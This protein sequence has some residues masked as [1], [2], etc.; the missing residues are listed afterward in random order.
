MPTS[1]APA[2]LITSTPDYANAPKPTQAP[3]AIGPKALN[4]EYERMLASGVAIADL[5]HTVWNKDRTSGTL[6]SHPPVQQYVP[7]NEYSLG[8]RS[9]ASEQELATR[10]KSSALPTA[11]PPKGK[12]WAPYVPQETVQEVPKTALPFQP[13]VQEVQESTNPWTPP[14]LPEISPYGA[15]PLASIWNANVPPQPAA[16]WNSQYQGPFEPPNEDGSGG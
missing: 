16:P 13:P 15:M 2:R 10:P 1:K 14:P 4:I 6:Q 3:A 7:Q 8:Y 5:P 11:I 12:Y 9:S